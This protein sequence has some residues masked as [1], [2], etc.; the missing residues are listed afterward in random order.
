MTKKHVAVIG[1][2][3]Q[4]GSDIV[5]ILSQKSNFTISALTH[6]HIDI[7]SMNSID[8]AL[9]NQGV[10]VVINTAAYH[11]VDEIEQ[12]PQKAIEVNAIGSRN[13]ALFCDRYKQI[14]VFISTDYV[15]GRDN[16]RAI[17]YSE[18]ELPEPVNTYGISKLA[19]EHFVRLFCSKYVI[20]RTSGLF[21]AQ[22]SSG[23][24]GNFVETMIQKARSG[25]I[26]NVVNDQ[27]LSPTS[28][29]NVA[30]QLAKLLSSDARGLYHITSEGECSWYEFAQQIF[31]YLNKHVRI[32]PV[33]SSDMPTRAK[34]PRYSVLAKN[35]LNR[36][37]INSMYHW[38]D[39]LRYYLQEKGYIP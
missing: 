6:A 3:G 39:A 32:K 34:R 8:R 33:P 15:F 38:K 11:K 13:L 28:T 36:E 5:K 17:P 30:N 35:H 26:I 14:L 18:L 37:G 9:G 19:G 1:A 24:G 16:T 12:F 31:L 7:T 22:G 25:E 21:G 10:D 23:K 4:L 2:N 27:I 20:C 29:A